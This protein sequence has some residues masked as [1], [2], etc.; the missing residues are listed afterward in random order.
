M[1]ILPMTKLSDTQ[2]VILGAAAQRADLSVMPLPDSLKL[3]GG[4]LT[5]VMD[6]LRNRGMI[7]VLDTDGGPERVVI[8]SEGMAAIGV[9]QEDDQAPAGATEPDTAPTSADGGAPAVE[10]PAPS[11]ETDSVAAP[12]KRKASRKAKAKSAPAASEPEAAPGQATG[13]PT[14]RAGT[15]QAKMIEMLK[16]PEGATVEQIAAATG[17]QHHTIR[18]A[19][20]GA[21][22]KKLGLT[23]EATRTR[24]VRPNK[25]GAKGS[26]TTYRIV[27]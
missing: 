19:I 1:E 11:A 10:A 14:P 25:S 12:A 5:K 22:K 6:A 7:R 15:K 4:A 8:T 13:K 27:E 3:K 18:G 24:E 2:L 16:R 17:W 23:V 26:A 20:S 21:L 9:E